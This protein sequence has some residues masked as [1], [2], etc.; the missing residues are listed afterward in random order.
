VNRVW[1]IRQGAVLLAA[2]V[3]P[4]GA[5]AGVLPS[6]ETVVVESRGWRLVGDWRAVPGEQPGPA[7]LLLHRAGGTRHEYA[8]LAD[9][10]ARRGIASLRLDLRGHGE[11]ANLGRFEP[12]YAEHRTV[13]ENTRED[14]EAALGWIASRPRVARDR[15]A[16]VGASYSGE[17]IGEALHLGGE[18]AAAYVMLS[19]GSFSDLSIAEIDPSGVPWLFIRSRE[20]SPASLEY[21]DAVFEALERGSR[22][23]EIRVLPRGGHATEILDVHPS[24]VEEIAAW[25]DSKLGEQAL[26]SQD[27]HAPSSPPSLGAPRG[28]PRREPV[29]A[30][31]VSLH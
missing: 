15:V 27:A 7:A 11:S 26:A 31:P 30:V 21:V 16:A 23:A 17:A 19:P 14:V 12:P 18:R 4:S 24:V 22:T 13:I 3:A 25:I 5:D 1:P 28:R 9:A 20:E 8:A 2:L 29:W 6:D 10:L